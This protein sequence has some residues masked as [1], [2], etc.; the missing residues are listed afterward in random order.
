MNCVQT[1]ILIFCKVLQLCDIDKKVNP[2]QQWAM[3]LIKRKNNKS[4]ECC[5]GLFHDFYKNVWYCTRYTK[6]FVCQKL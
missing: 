3:Q 2:N 6:E 5:N 4:S 1:Q